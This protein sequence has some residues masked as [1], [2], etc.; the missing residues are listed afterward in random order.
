MWQ[1]CLIVPLPT[2]LSKVDVL[3]HLFFFFN[4]LFGLLGCIS[5]KGLSGVK[6]VNERADIC[7]VFFCFELQFLLFV[8]NLEFCCGE[9]QTIA[10]V[11]FG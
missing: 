1:G 9:S 7:L 2:P 3:L 11:L 6:V 4:L 8:G 5:V 10:L